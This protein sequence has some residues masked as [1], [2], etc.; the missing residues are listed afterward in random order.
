M[1]VVVGSRFPGGVL[2]VESPVKEEQEAAESYPVYVT[3]SPFSEDLMAQFLTFFALR[4]DLKSKICIPSET[5]QRKNG[6]GATN[7]SWE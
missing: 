2:P 5:S 4:P 3:E 1:V 6:R 7:S